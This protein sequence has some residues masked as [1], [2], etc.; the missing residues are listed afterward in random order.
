M[1]AL[2]VYFCF[3]SPTSKHLATLGGRR[4][5]SVQARRRRRSIKGVRQRNPRT[6]PTKSAFL[7]LISGQQKGAAERGHVKKRQKSTKSVKNIFDTFRHFSHRA[8]TSRIVK[9]CQKDFRH[10][11]TIFARHQFSGPFWGALPRV[12]LREVY[13]AQAPRTLPS[14]PPRLTLLRGRFGI[15]MIQIRKSMSNQCRIDA[16]PMPNR[17]LRRVRRGGFNEVRRVCA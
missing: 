3:I 13:W 7:R 17:Q 5:Q 2:G 10:L 15:E 4:P 9:K 1:V 16:E 14:N 6:T 8:K 12:R 11:L